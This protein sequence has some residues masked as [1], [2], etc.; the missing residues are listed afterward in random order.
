MPATIRD[1]KDLLYPGAEDPAVGERL[2]ED[3]LSRGHV[4]A[5]TL[6]T[7][8]LEDQPDPAWFL[9]RFIQEESLTIIYGPPK[10]G[11]T[12][13]CVEWANRLALGKEW[14][15][16]KALPTRVLYASAEG[17][18][19][20]GM[21]TRAL[22]AHHDLPSPENLRWLPGVTQLYYHNE[23]PEA[24]HELILAINDF[25]PHVVF[26][27]TLARHTPGGDVASNHDM[28]TVVQVADELRSGFGCS[29]VF[30]HH[31]RKD[32]GDYL[33]ATA[34]YGAAD[35]MVH[36]KPSK[37]RGRF[38]LDVISK[39]LDDYTPPW[40]FEIVPSGDSAVVSEGN[41]HI[42]GGKMDDV[43]AYID[44]AGPVTATDV[45]FAIFETEGKDSANYIKQL[46][47]E[48]KIKQ[49]GERSEGRGRPAKLWVIPDN[50]LKEY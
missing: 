23:R 22:R 10:T 39:E 38:D 30:V 18:K 27:D 43:L 6:T 40:T 44:M 41:K 13:L 3:A 8:E 2:V 4:P 15:G 25:Q 32:G 28:S 26:F 42:P 11:K 33:G 45:Q 50:G 14:L 49:E 48:G 46:A 37:T 5:K 12:F 7:Q 9:E 36:L 20:L 47:D 35:T 21:R 31:T 1:L 24:Q 16:H 17:N 29:V 19:S 34:L